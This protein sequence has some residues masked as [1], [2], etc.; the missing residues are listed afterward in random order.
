MPSPSWSTAL[1]LSVVLVCCAASARAELNNGWW[2]I[3]G[4]LPEN[5]TNSRASEALHNKIGRCGFKAF[6]DWSW[7]FSGF[8]PGYTVYVLGA[9]GTKAE[10]NSILASAKKCVPDAYIKQGTYAGE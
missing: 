6:N 8:A 4:V 10:A 3:V 2:I 5:N 7:K 1:L 9:Y